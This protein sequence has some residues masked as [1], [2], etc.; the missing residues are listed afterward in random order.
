MTGL[1]PTDLALLKVKSS[2]MVSAS[3]STVQGKAKVD[4]LNILQIEIFAFQA[5]ALHH[6]PIIVHIIGFS[7][8]T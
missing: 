8:L 4:P 6:C 1:T 7:L 5:I 2:P 3:T